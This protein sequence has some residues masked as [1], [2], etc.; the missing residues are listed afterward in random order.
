MRVADMS[1]WMGPMKT[2]MGVCEKGSRH[3][4]RRFGVRFLLF[5]SWLGCF[6]G[7]VL[8]GWHLKVCMS[9]H[10]RGGTE[11]RSVGFCTWCVYCCQLKWMDGKSG[12]GRR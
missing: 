7:G 3:E 11:E 10:E 12:R 5:W 4:T 9:G 2:W 6:Q 8:I 1:I